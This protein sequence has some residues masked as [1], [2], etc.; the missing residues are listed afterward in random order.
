MAT[1]PAA[2]TP[3]RKSLVR[4]LTV[5]VSRVFERGEMG[6]EIAERLTDRLARAR[7][8]LSGEPD[9]AVEAFLT[10]M[11]RGY[12]LFV[13]PA[14]AA[15]H[16]ST[17]APDI[18]VHEV[19]TVSQPGVAE[20]SYELLV[21]ATDHPG[22]LS[23]IAGS[24]A[25]AGLSVRS[26]QVFTTSDHIAADLFEVQGS[27]GVAV[28]EDRWRSF[29]K[30]LR[31]AVEGRTSLAHQVEEKRRY[32]PASSSASA[33]TVK[34]DNAASDFYTVVEVGAPDRIG[35]LFDI[36]KTLADLEL[37]VHV[38]KVA[39]YPGRVIDAFYVRHV[40]GTKVTDAD[41]VASIEAA[42]HPAPVQQG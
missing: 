22:L 29:R 25:L 15:K 2:W 14:Q 23:Q 8:L 11:P 30:T 38:A 42:F 40:D 24:L 28:E 18:G 1:G 9:A 35:L 4:E 17:I 12:F 27:F 13:E 21:V 20:D 6:T 16:F 34:V 41:E 7:E 32:Y 26:A 3:W 39:T 33:V 36:T 10:R 37:D 19:R 31:R 5:R